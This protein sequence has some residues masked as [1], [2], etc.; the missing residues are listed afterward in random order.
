M[1]TLS[2]Y[3]SR[4]AVA[5]S[6]LAG[7][8]AVLSPARLARATEYHVTTAGDDGAD[9]SV[10]R[11]WAT[12]ERGVEA[13]V[14][15]DTLTVHEG[16]YVVATKILIQGKAGTADLPIVLRADGVVILEDSRAELP[17]WAGLID[18]RDSSWVTVSGFT[19]LR[20]RFFG[21]FFQDCDHV[22]AEGNSTSESRA[23]GIASWSSTHVT[24][25]GNDVAS[26]CNDG[27]MVP[28]RWGTDMGC[29]ECIS[30]DTTDG[31]LV[32][33]N[34]VHDAQ[35]SG[36][37]HWGG[38]E[39][40]DVKNGSSNGAVI[41]NEVRDL[42]QL[43]IYVEAWENDLA[44]VEVA[45]N[46]VYRTANGIVISSEQTGDVDDVR[47]HDNVVHDIGFGGISVSHYDVAPNVVANVRVYNNTVAHVGYPENKPYFLPPAE[48]SATWGQGIVVGKPDV[49]AV[50]IRDNV[51]WDIGG[52]E[53]IAL[54]AGL[55]GQTVEGNVT[56]DPLFLDYAARDLRIGAGSPAI[57]AGVG[58]REAADVDFWGNVRVAGAAV[59][60][61]AFEYG[62]EPGAGGTGGNPP[63]GGA[64]ASGGTV[65][66]GGTL[67][68]GGVAAGGGAGPSGGADPSGSGGGGPSAPAEGAADD[69]G[70]G[71][72]AA[73]GERP[74]GIAS[75]L[76]G[77][78]AVLALGRGPRRRSL[79]SSRRG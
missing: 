40:I 35:Q 27:Q 29:Q 44:N 50:T 18:V 56:S 25:R 52:G 24:I 17:D 72:V 68:V 54:A 58:V 69:G 47:V 34:V 49:V 64:G 13:L 26:A 38:G 60:V 61:G 78:L 51:I 57:D 3:A 14:P 67:G 19:L 43:G 2:P 37:A 53:A 6:G 9:G 21:I 16:T 59:D 39:G 33:A 70:C 15:G 4:L 1:R 77:V 41:G 32:E 45:R 76:A 79:A 36:L 23:S 20:P 7:A 5:A 46:H 42:V 62:S 28:S 73:G 30:L 31:F 71:C 22:V 8:L 11:P 75:L 10:A 63:S 55:T 12:V 65:A 48:R 66:V 74:A